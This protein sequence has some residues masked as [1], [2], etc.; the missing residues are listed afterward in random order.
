MIRLPQQATPNWRRGDNP[1]LISEKGSL[2]TLNVRTPI[3][4]SPLRA[5]H[6]TLIPKVA[7]SPQT[8]VPTAVP[9]RETRV[10]NSADSTSKRSSEESVATPGKVLLS[11]N[12]TPRSGSRKARLGSTASTPND[13]PNGTPKKPRPLSYI[14]RSQLGLAETNGAIEPNPGNGVP[15]RQIRPRSVISDGKSSS[16]S[17][18]ATSPET[19]QLRS[20]DSSPLFFHAND[21]KSSAPKRPTLPA[22]NPSFVYANGEE[23]TLY[24]QSPMGASPSIDDVRPQFFHVDSMQ[25]PP[26]RKDRATSSTSTSSKQPENRAQRLSVSLLP[27]VVPQQPPSPP[28]DVQVQPQ[29]QVKRTPSLSKASPRTHTR[30]VSN[31]GTHTIEY[32]APEP[33]SP[34]RTSTARRSSLNTPATYQKNHT[35][36]SSVTSLGSISNHRRSLDLKG[37]NVGI[38]NHGRKPLPRM[39]STVMSSAVERDSYLEGGEISAEDLASSPPQSPDISSPVPSPGKSRLEH[40]NELA[41]NARRERK[42]LDLEIS[43]SSLLAINQT[44]EKEMRKQKAELRRFRRLTRSGRLSMAPSDRSASGKYSIITSSDAADEESRMDDDREIS[45]LTDDDES[46]LLSDMTP[47]SPN[48]QISY[49]TRQCRRDEKRLQLDLSKQRALLQDS[50]RMNQSLKR[51]L[52]WTDELI[53]ECKKALE[54]HVEVRMGGRVLAIDELAPDATRSRGLLSPGLEEA[55]NPLDVGTWFN[56]A[57]GHPNI[58]AE[59]EE[60]RQEVEDPLNEETSFSQAEGG[61]HIT[62]EPDE[63]TEDTFHPSPSRSNADNVPS[64]NALFLDGD[65]LSL[66]GLDTEDEPVSLDEEGSDTIDD[67][68]S[69]KD[70]TIHST[71]V[72]TPLN[73][74]ARHN[75]NNGVRPMLRPIDKGGGKRLGQYLNS[76]GASWGI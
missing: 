3:T 55:K 63:V 17:W 19:S 22:K 53:A 30:L 72:F 29:T 27:K 31:G 28:K 64:P 32:K 49:D 57:E 71:K 1:T 10:D 37:N 47:L 15:D 51:C 69:N 74:E 58:S 12:I 61:S 23:E 62:T 60:W 66:D 42:V 18:R 21:A 40:L 33:Q 50:Q 5:E 9:R 70:E 43:N 35:R 20:G 14:G 56:E 54:Y 4:S 48:F 38:I 45:Y 2:G 73:N 26:S 13:T 39:L 41:T 7:S 59:P 36:S 52:D 75:L 68:G 8:F 76:L 16:L 6:G 65:Q 24:M 11:S 67:E 44:L 46:S 25:T 34:S